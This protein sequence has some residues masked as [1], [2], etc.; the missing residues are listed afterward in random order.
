MNEATEKDLLAL[1]VMNLAKASILVDN[2]FLAGAI[3]RLIP[4]SRVLFRPLATD[5]FLLYFD[6]NRLLR[7]FRD[8]AMPPTHDMLHSVAHCLFLHPYVGSAVDRNLWNLACDIVAERMVADLLGSRTDTQAA[9]RMQII[10]QVERALG[11]RSGAERIYRELREGRWADKVDAWSQILQAD[12]HER[13]YGSATREGDEE[14]R[15]N[16]D[17]GAEGSAQP[18]SNSPFQQNVSRPSATQQQQMWRN[19]ATAL[20]VNLQTLSSARGDDLGNLVDDLQVASQFRADFATFLRRFATPGEAM[21]INDDEFDQNF[22]TYGLRLYDTLP[23]IEPLEYREEQ[24]IREFVIVLDTS[25]SVQGPA[26][27]SFVSATFA[28]LKSTESFFQQVHI[29]VIQCDEAVRSDVTLSSMADLDS[30]QQSMRIRGGGG[31]D[32]RPAFAYVDALVDAGEFWDLG[33]L[34]Y[35]T[36]GL[37]TYPEWVPRYRSA[38]VFYDQDYPSSSVPPWALQVTLDKDTLSALVDKSANTTRKDAV[39]H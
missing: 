32:F 9:M 36:D 1:E 33:G 31:T 26:I 22:Y 23:L 29:S 35:F 7:A 39:W 10:E 37:G 30:W 3:G 2:H 8:G 27:R 28:L 20:A 11:R 4:Q 38:F 19:T 18:D 16:A 13:W 15:G 21:R 34:V 17:T 24:R 14:G 6:S 5:G 25:E 12:S